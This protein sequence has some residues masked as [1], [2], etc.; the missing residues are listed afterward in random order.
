MSN[1]PDHIEN[2]G[3]YADAIQ[4]RIKENARKTRERKFAEDHP[5]LLAE[6]KDLWS[7][8]W[9]EDVDEWQQDGSHLVLHTMTVKQRNALLRKMGWLHDGYDEYGS[10]T[11]AQTVKA[12]TIIAETKAN[13]S[14]WE[15]EDELRKLN[16]TPWPTTLGRVE[17]EVEVVSAKIKSQ[18]SF[19]PYDR[20]MDISWKMVVQREDGSRAWG[21]VP[22]VLRDWVDAQMQA[23]NEDGCIWSDEKTAARYFR[24]TKLLLRGTFTRAD[25]DPVFAFF[26]RPHVVAI[27]EE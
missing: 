10:L 27:H 19:N 22:S 21:S 15:D 24:G 25:D 18:P 20:S 2:P 1:I 14:K 4:R 8:E 7:P 17:Y 9:N 26:K 13:V 23:N 5:E 11:P 12:K 3:A 6:L 16:A